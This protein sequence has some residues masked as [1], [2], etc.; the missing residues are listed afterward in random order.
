M[1]SLRDIKNRINNINS[2]AKITQS[3]KVISTSR[4]Y[5][6]KSVRNGN[7]KYFSSVNK[8][9]KTLFDFHK[10]LKHSKEDKILHAI[11][12]GESSLEGKTLVI[13]IQSDRGLC[14]GYNGNITKSVLKRIDDLGR[15]NCVLLPIGNKSIF[16]ANKHYADITL[17][18]N[19]ISELKNIKEEQILLIAHYIMKLF[20]SDAISKVE[21]HYT[22]SKSLLEQIVEVK[23]LL[24]ILNEKIISHV[25]DKKTNEINN[26]IPEEVLRIV[27][28]EYNFD[29][30]LNTLLVDYFVSCLYDCL[31]LS[32]IAEYASRLQA[33]DNAYNNSKD[34]HKDLQLL[35]NRKRQGKIT[36]E[37]VEIIS[38][39]NVV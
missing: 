32:S 33:M 6:A 15:E 18:I 7:S 4:L 38:G 36:E 34:L 11:F 5:F 21:V 24:P 17:P 10:N 23:S 28:D 39:A 14:G 12:S 20:N 8:S 16:F 25:N 9:L 1:A 29:T 22:Y 26:N 31:T 3:M 19:T 27:V 13:F 2:I 37:L 35:Y 30:T